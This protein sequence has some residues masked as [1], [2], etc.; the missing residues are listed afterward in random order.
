[1]VVVK[2]DTKVKLFIYKKLKIKVFFYKM[3]LGKKLKV[4]LLV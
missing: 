4:I 2:N 1:M 3:W